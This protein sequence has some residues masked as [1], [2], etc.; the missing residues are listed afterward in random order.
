MVR[1]IQTELDKKNPGNV[2]GNNSDDKNSLNG[3]QQVDDEND[4]RRIA[5]REMR[6]LEQYKMQKY[7]PCIKMTH[8]LGNKDPKDRSLG[9]WSGKEM[10]CLLETTLLT[11]S[12]PQR[13]NGP[14]HFLQGA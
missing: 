13:A 6:R 12:T 3:I 11:S 10:I 1:A 8:C 7:L 14:T 9:R 5:E 2:N 4:N